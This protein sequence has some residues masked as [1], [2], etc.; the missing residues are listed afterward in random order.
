MEFDEIIL[1]ANLMKMKIPQPNFK[2]APIFKTR[3]SAA[4][5][6]R[7]WMRVTLR[8]RASFP[9]KQLCILWPKPQPAHG[10]FLSLFNRYAIV[11][12]YDKLEFDGTQSHK[13]KAS[14]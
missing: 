11:F 6:K 13:T 3:A 8:K 12:S 7:D 10:Y 14:D 1:K 5:S 2:W 4:A 9:F